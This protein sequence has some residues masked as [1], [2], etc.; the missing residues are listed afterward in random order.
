MR[1]SSGYPGEVLAWGCVRVVANS[2]TRD[3]WVKVYIYIISKT[4]FVYP[5][6]VTIH[7]CK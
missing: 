4:K 2:P 3:E 1:D 6:T 5:Y 7:T